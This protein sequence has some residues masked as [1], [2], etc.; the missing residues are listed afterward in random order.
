MV[1]T[2]AG[3]VNHRME[4]RIHRDAIANMKLSRLPFSTD[5]HNYRASL[6]M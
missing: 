5:S 1:H 6:H 3:P 2:S 4:E